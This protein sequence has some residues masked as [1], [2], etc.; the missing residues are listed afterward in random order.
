MTSGPTEPKT[1]QEA[2]HSPEERNNWQIAIRK[3]TKSMIN[4]GVW[5]KFDKVKKPENRRLIGNKWVFK[6]KRYGTNRVRLVALGYSQIPGVD[7][8]DNF[9]PLAHDVS[10]RM[11][12]ARMM[13]EKL[14]TFVMHVETAFLYGD[15]EENFFMKSPVRMEEID[16]RS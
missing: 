7:Y 2:W 15:I 13:V 1:F 9:T 5:S 3:E 8:K 11:A 4:R 14:D 12:L 10:F 16:P 6:I